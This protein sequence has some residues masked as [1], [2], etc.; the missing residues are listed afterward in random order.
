MRVRNLEL[1]YTKNTNHRKT[2]WHK[3]GEQTTW[4]PLRWKKNSKQNGRALKYIGI[5]ELWPFLRHTNP[6]LFVLHKVCMDIFM[7]HVAFL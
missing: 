7:L 4:M 5:P 2:K 3:T 1:G 6:A